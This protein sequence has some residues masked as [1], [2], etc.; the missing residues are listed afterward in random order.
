MIGSGTLM[1]AGTSL[2]CERLHR[3]IGRKRAEPVRLHG[4][5]GRQVLLLPQLEELAGILAGHRHHRAALLVESEDRAGGERAAERQHAV[6]LGIGEQ[7]AGHRFLRRGGVVGRVG[8]GKNLDVR[9]GLQHRRRRRR[10]DPR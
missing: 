6:D 9:I 3:G 1:K 4:R 2:P 10:D 7:Q 8:L 5:P